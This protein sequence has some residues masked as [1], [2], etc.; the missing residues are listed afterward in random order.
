MRSDELTELTELLQT[1]SRTLGPEAPPD[2]RALIG[3]V[4]HRRQAVGLALAAALVLL[5]AAAVP[6]LQHR[7]DGAIDVAAGGAAAE[8]VP[9]PPPVDAAAELSAEPTTTT[10]P[11]EPTPPPAVTTAPTPSTASGPTT[12]PPAAAGPTVTTGAPK[13]PTVPTTPTTRGPGVPPELIAASGNAAAPR[14]MLRFSR[15]VVPGDGPNFDRPPSAPSPPTTQDTYMAA[16]QLV[17]HQSDSTCS[18]PQGNA[19][20]YLAGVGT[21]T[22][23]VD[24]TS[25]VVGTTYIS[26]S[27]GFAKSAD[28]GTAMVGVRCIPITVKG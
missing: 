14:V 18:N 10:T 1:A 7:E 20:E 2:P 28:D 22:L 27:P 21:D 17:V 26:I 5:A 19:H 8:V 13:P 6:A 4:R 23:T 25:L 3:R 16:M 9:D 24:A 15:P 11:P 12:A